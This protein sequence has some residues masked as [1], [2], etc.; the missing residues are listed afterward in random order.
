MI[1]VWSWS[2]CV[3]DRSLVADIVHIYSKSANNEIIVWSVQA[4]PKLLFIASCETRRLR[5]LRPRE[6]SYTTR[7]DFHMRVNAPLVVVVVTIGRSSEIESVL[8]SI[9][10]T[11]ICGMMTTTR[12]EKRRSRSL[13]KLD[14]ARVVFQFRV[15]VRW[16]MMM[17]FEQW[18]H[19]NW[20]DL[21]LKFRPIQSVRSGKVCCGATSWP[22]WKRE[23]ERYWTVEVERFS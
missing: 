3:I 18:F 14:R 6:Q 13:L 8:F 19:G 17:M 11:S 7:S 15:R 21:N 16:T 22:S 5:R 9:T 12:M 4:V 20:F 2:C 10:H 1:Y 23:S